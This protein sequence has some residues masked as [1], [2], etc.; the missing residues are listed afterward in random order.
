MALIKGLKFGD[1]V[2]FE[3]ARVD[4]ALT[5]TRIEKRK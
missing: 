5:V 3:S 4:G 1:A 2:R